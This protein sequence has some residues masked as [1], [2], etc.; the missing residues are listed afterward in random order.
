MNTTVV[1]IAGIA[2]S[3]KNTAAEILRVLLLEKGSP[4]VP[5]SVHILPLA[6]PLKTG[7]AF[8]SASD[9]GS[10]LL[11]EKLGLPNDYGPR[12][13]SVYPLVQRALAAALFRSAMDIDGTKEIFRTIL[14]TV[15]TEVFH[16]I[17]SPRVWVDLL[18]DRI[19][20]YPEGSVFIVPDVRFPVEMEVLRPLL[21][22]ESPNGVFLFGRSRNIQ[23]PRHASE[24]SVL[25]LEEYVRGKIPSILP[26]DNS[27][28][29]EDLYEAL[30]PVARSILGSFGNRTG[31]G[32][33]R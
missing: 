26:V 24:T 15:G 29:V 18:V 16:R 6:D 32:G 19:S 33:E 14:Q 7:A 4:L 27:G 8:H 1:P 3:G 10:E 5:G 28:T 13:L 9:R 30:E 23:T 12:D 17:Y 25:E 20:L 31:F 22:R 2:G 21:C 11:F